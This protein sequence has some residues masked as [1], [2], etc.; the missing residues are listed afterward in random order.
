MTDE[1][2]SN[3]A[4]AVSTSWP[5]PGPAPKFGVDQSDGQPDHGDGT[6]GASARENVSVRSNSNPFGSPG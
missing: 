1:F 4:H 2:R 3:P 5:K 6:H